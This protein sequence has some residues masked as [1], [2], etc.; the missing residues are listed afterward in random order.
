[1]PPRVISTNVKNEI[2]ILFLSETRAK[3]GYV[4]FALTCSWKT[5][6]DNRLHSWSSELKL[7]TAR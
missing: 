3:Y 1:M 7:A 4:T 2:V 6:S 5:E